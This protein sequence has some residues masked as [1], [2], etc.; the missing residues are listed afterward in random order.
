MRA[1]PLEV[2]LVEDHEPDAFTVTRFAEQLNRDAWARDGRPS[3]NLHRATRLSEAIV[4]LKTNDFD[5]AL[6]DL[7]LP[8]SFA[9]HTLR[10]I[11]T[12]APQLAVVVLTGSDDDKL[13][14]KAVAEGAQDYLLKEGLTPARLWRALQFAWERQ[15]SVNALREATLVDSLTGLYSRRGFHS[16]A[17]ACLALP[18]AGPVATVVLAELANLPSLVQLQGQ[19]VADLALIDLAET[20]RD[21]V[22]DEGMLG[23]LDQG[24]FAAL[25]FEQT[26]AVTRLQASLEG[27]QRAPRTVGP[28]VILT[29][30]ARGEGGI[31][32]LILQARIHLH[33]RSHAHA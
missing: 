6:L 16:L 12:Q 25:V 31:E 24:L 28:V 18:A 2:L 15:R 22:R 9:L 27:F 30:S 11:T 14:A 20:L 5:A 8:D 17:G 26:G 32:E 13:A 33:A 29:G 3:L 21:A 23:R 1:L 10:A 19:A 7:T 4:A